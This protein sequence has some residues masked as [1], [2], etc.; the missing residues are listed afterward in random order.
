MAATMCL[1]LR[2]DV[3][4]PAQ[5]LLLRGT[6]VTAPVSAPARPAASYDAVRSGRTFVLFLALLL[7][8]ALAA[9]GGLIWPEPAQGDWYTWSDLAPIRDW[10]FLLLTTLASGLVINVP[11]Q[12]LA[13]VLLSP[14]RGAGWSTAG[15]LLMWVGTAVYAVGAAGWAFAYYVA[16]D[17][18][19]GQPAATALVERVGEDPR[20]FALAIPGA[21]M[22]A[23]GTALQAVGLLRAHTVPRWVPLASLAVLATFILPN[24][25]AWGLVTAIPVAVASIALGWLAW[26]QIRGGTDVAAATDFYRQP[27]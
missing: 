10:W 5:L 16:T 17:P 12:A 21:L 27:T 3:L 20:T 9:A 13:A 24:A 15:A 26:R 18:E 7:S 8:A 19:L 4:M 25:G 23:A 2:A 6:R 1:R 11:A 14:R 22:V